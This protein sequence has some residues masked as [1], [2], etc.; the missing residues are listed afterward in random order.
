MK[1]YS[2]AIKYLESFNSKNSQIVLMGAFGLERCKYLIKLMNNPQDKYQVVHVA[3][4]S[5]KGSVAYITSKILKTTKRRIGLHQTPCLGE[6][7]ELIQINN[8]AISQ[9]K[10]TLYLS[11]IQPFVDKMDSLPFGRPRYFE[12]IIGLTYWTFWQERV[13][14]A[15]IEVALGGL[16]DCT[17]TIS[18]PSKVSVI[19]RLGLDH[20]D[21]LGNTISEIA[22][23]KAGII[24]Q[25]NQ[26]IALKSNK[27]SDQIIAHCAS[28]YNNKLYQVGKINF[29]IVNTDQGGSVFNFEFEGLQ[30][31]SLKLSLVGDF[32]VEN[33]SIAIA[34]CVILFKQLKISLE[35]S[36]ITT[37]C[38]SMNF[39]GRFHISRNH[40]MTWIVDGA[41]N[42]QKMEALVG[43]IIKLFPNISFNILFSC[44]GGKNISEMIKI[45]SPIINNWFLV[46]FTSHQSGFTRPIPNEVLEREIL[47]INSGAKIHKL[48]STRKGLQLITN[49]R[50]E[51]NLITGSLY[52]L[53]DVYKIKFDIFGQ[54]VI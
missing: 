30:I 45:L 19:G 31:D 43:S 36:T 35:V 2:D 47:H 28:K 41:H 12:V 21:F 26:I 53:S 34:V 20:Q 37:A 22:Y 33:C 49:L 23:Q 52:L 42:P 51:H 8:K 1:N 44:K 17:N 3:G 4:T 32:Q 40:D 5:G 11:Q 27:V 6:I 7:T 48:S 50:N 10:F 29:D 9:E 38:M 16:Y 25:G 54:S 46:E 39:L 18:N 13:D 15:V 24:K 14:I